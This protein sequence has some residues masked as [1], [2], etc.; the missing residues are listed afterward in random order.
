MRPRH[1]DPKNCHGDGTGIYGLDP[2]PD[3]TYRHFCLICEYE[4]VVKVED[5][6]HP[7]AAI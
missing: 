3:G 7:V 4:A 2:L 5:L 6:R 1:H